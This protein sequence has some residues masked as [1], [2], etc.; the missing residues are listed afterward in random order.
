MRYRDFELGS[1]LTAITALTTT[2]PSQVKIVHARPA[3][4]Q[5]FEWRPRY[6]SGS[7][8]SPTDPV[9]LVTFNFYNDQLFE[10]VVDY[11]R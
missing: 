6:F 10:I 5:A 9:A 3:V 7:G 4:I 2:P 8:S 1:N 11:D